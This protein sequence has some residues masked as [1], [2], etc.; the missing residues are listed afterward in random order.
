M[1]KVVIGSLAILTWLKVTEKLD[2]IKPQESARKYPSIYSPSKAS[3]LPDA[4]TSPA[5]NMPTKAVTMMDIFSFLNSM[6][7]E[8]ITIHRDHVV[9]KIPPSARGA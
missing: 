4:I 2:Q 1:V 6:T 7:E 5:P 9:A 8:K 3:S